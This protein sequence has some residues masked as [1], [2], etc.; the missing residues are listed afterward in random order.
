[1]IIKGV[2]STNMSIVKNP[3][4]LRR[5][6]T[7]SSGQ[8]LV[9]FA[10]VL[11]LLLLILLGIIEISFALYNQDILVKLAREGSNLISRDTTL[12]DAASAMVSISSPPVDFNTSR[13]KLIFSV[14]YQGTT[15]GNAG[16][17]ILYQRLMIGNLNASS[18]LTT[19]GTGSYGG[20]PNY[21]ALNANN[22]VNLQIINLPPNVILQDNGY[23]FLTEVYSGYTPI[24]PFQNL[25]FQLPSNLYAS[26]YF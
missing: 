9:E 12:Q 16:K 11:P 3:Y 23:I 18:A 8:V 10:L 7:V 25:G 5:I 13:S 6:A 21:V 19:R 24:G 17:P 2:R 15:G 22:D 14:I 4:R 1:M 26:A 20:P